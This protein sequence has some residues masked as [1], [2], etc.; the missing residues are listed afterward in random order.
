MPLG[1]IGGMLIGMASLIATVLS[2]RIP[3][4]SG[5]LGRVLVPVT[6]DKAWRLIFLLGLIGGAALTFSCWENAARFHPCVRLA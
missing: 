4:I 3:G 1:I 6:T 5:V 2:G